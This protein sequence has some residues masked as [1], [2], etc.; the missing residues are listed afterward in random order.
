M[1][2]VKAEEAE[3]LKVKSQCGVRGVTS[4][5]ISTIRAP[6]FFAI[7]GIEAAG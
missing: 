7:R 1:I 4:G 6:L 5:L 2:S 3:F